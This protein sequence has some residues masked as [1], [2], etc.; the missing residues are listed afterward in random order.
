MK[1]LNTYPQ[2]NNVFYL[3]EP[4]Q[5]GFEELY[6]RLREAEGRILSDHQVRSLPDLVNHP[7]ENEWKLRKESTSRIMNYLS[8]KGTLHILE[9]GCGNGWFSNHLAGI[10]SNQVIGQDIN[11][12]ELEQASRCFQRENLKFICC[13]DLSL[14]R[15]ETF[16]LILF[17]GSIQYFSNLSEV[18]QTIIP[19][20]KPQGEIHVI[21]SPIYD[22]EEAVLA[23]KNRSKAYYKKHGA[24]KL[25]EHYHHHQYGEFPIEAIHYQPSRLK[26]L[27]GQKNPFPW[28]QIRV[29]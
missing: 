7:L 8:G 10:N 29:S 21:D 2:V 12:T 3:G 23:A 26:K 28:I 24:D 19:K 22:S 11:L 20:L 6:V 13:S 18:F 1:H 14:F 15:D 16:D 5:S 9:V 17:N 25:A 27:T 4:D